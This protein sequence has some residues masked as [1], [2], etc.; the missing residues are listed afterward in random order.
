[1]ILFSEKNLHTKRLNKKFENRYYRLFKITDTQ[2]K[3][4]YKLELS[5]TFHI[6]NMFH[7]KLLKKAQSGTRGLAELSS[8]TVVN[9]HSE[10]E[11]FEVDEVLDSKYFERCLKYL[12][13]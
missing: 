8:I 1:M 4:A 2:S 10:H 9:E 3:Q 12:I 5:E 7:V 6:H 13:R 11:E